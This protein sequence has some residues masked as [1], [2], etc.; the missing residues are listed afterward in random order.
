VIKP[1]INRKKNWNKVRL[2]WV[3]HYSQLLNRTKPNPSRNSNLT[4]KFIPNGGGVMKRE[5]KDE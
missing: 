1:N 5:L 4:Q 2:F 3:W